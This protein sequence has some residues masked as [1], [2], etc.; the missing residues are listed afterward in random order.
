MIKQHKTSLQKYSGIYLGQY[1]NIEQL[2]IHIPY[3]EILD[4]L[5]I[6]IGGCICKTFTK[7]SNG[8]PSNYFI[9]NIDTYLRNDIYYSIEVHFKKTSDEIEMSNN[10]VCIS[11]YASE[12]Y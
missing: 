9:Y 6:Q 11:V 7:D 2:Q 5:I 1:R 3:P 4:K 8:W 12:I 10:D